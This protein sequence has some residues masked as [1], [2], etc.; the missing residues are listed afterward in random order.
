MTRRACALAAIVTLVAAAAAPRDDAKEA[1]QNAIR[2]V[3]LFETKLTEA[4][5]ALRGEAIRRTS[6]S[7]PVEASDQKFFDGHRS[8]YAG[9]G[10]PVHP[11]PFRHPYPHL[12]TN[13]NYDDDFVKDDNE[14]HGEYEAMMTYDTIRAKIHILQEKV[15]VDESRVVSE[16]EIVADL[17]AKLKAAKVALR[18]AEEALAQAEKVLRQ[19]EAKSKAVQKKIDAQQKVVA[20]E[21]KEFEECKKR[22]AAAQ[23]NFAAAKASFASNQEV[24]KMELAIEKTDKQLNMAADRLRKAGGKVDEGDMPRQMPAPQSGSRSRATLGA[25]GFVVM[26]LAEAP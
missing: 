6:V 9:D 20:R 2:S 7:P 15:R 1:V 17:R 5:A 21:R 10:R 13:D 3:Q 23:A 16:G 4:R 18:K 19:W 24:Q 14:D 26:M 22:L 11:E 8:D 25:L 12:Q